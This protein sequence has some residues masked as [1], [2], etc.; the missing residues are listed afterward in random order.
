MG[1]QALR[2]EREE[3]ARQVAA[4]EAGALAAVQRAA[5]ATGERDVARQMLRGVQ[6]MLG[7]AEGARSAAQRALQQ[8]QAEKAASQARSLE[9]H[10]PSALWAHCMHVCV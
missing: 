1:S 7:H 4:A 6:A 3:Q 5:D 8:A 9:S 10:V 2:R